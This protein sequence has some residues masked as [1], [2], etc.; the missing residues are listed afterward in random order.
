MHGSFLLPSP[1]DTPV[2]GRARQ[3]IGGTADRER[4]AHYSNEEM[5]N[6]PFYPITRTVPRPAHGRCDK[7]HSVLICPVVGGA[8]E[9]S[10]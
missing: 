9:S 4:P 7:Y 8:L 2:C 5:A 3:V 1:G 10:E 6:M